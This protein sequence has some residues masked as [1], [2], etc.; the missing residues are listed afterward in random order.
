MNFQIILEYALLFIIYSFFGWCM[1][2]TY[3]SISNKKFVNRGF[4]LGPVCPIYAYGA[5]LITALNK[6]FSD[7]I[8]LFFMTI[9]VCGGLEYFTSWIMEVLFKAR[10]W[11]YSNK[12]F[13]LNGRI[14]LKNLL[15]FG[16]LGLVVAY[17]LNPLF[18]TWI[19]KLKVNQL[20]MYTS[21]LIGIYLLDTIISFIVI[22]SFRKVT[23]EVNIKRREDN[24]EQITQMVRELFSQK[25]FLHRRFINAYPKLEA[26]KTKMK[27]IKTK[28]EDVTNDAK[29][30]V[31]EKVNDAKDIVV[32]KTENIRNTIE[33]NTKKVKI[34]ISLRTEHL[35]ESFK[36]KIRKERG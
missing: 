36:G 10:W 21:I 32:E 22:F 31:L 34:K 8:V 16:I 35:K 27:E 1:E 19:F 11:D 18:R 20:Y 26:I 14:C 33:R 5:L 2:T 9:I 24:T 17:V 25:S 29:D 3:V 28:I 23:E 30:A 15:A 13:N 12:K 4:L 6:F 7:P